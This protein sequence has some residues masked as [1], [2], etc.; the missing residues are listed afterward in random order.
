MP[1]LTLLRPH[2]WTLAFGPTPPVL[3]AL[4]L[5]IRDLYRPAGFPLFPGKAT[6]LQA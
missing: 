3:R 1:F 6:Q 5:S 2:V 4:C